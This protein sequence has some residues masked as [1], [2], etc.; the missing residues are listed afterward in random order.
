MEQNV[1]QAEIIKETEVYR[2]AV[3]V[4]PEIP[5]TLETEKPEKV[6]KAEEVARSPEVPLVTQST[7]MELFD[8]KLLSV[9]A[10]K[11]HR[12]IGQI[13][14]TGWCRWRINFISLTSM[15]PMKKFFM[16]ESSIKSRIGR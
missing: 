11:H 2:P 13:F 4:S 15:Q 8:G 1:Q 7:Q 10:K 12:I 5:K 16:S 9:E 6:T 3:S 14:V